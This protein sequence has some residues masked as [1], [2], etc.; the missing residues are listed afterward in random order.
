MGGRIHEIWVWICS[1][2]SLKSKINIRRVKGAWYLLE[3]VN[4]MF[5][6][7]ESVL[8][9][10]C[11]CPTDTWE[12]T[13]KWKAQSGTSYKSF[14]LWD[15]LAKYFWGKIYPSKSNLKVIKTEHKTQIF[16]KSIDKA[17]VQ[18][19]RANVLCIKDQGCKKFIFS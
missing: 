1:F 3:Q 18:E 9:V 5:T 4:R 11:L 7:S 2:R 16:P 15:F 14:Y 12:Q 13:C 17:R 6:A 8:A 10:P 19:G